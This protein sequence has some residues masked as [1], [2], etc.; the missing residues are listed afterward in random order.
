MSTKF[1]VL[2]KNGDMGIW[3]MAVD[4]AIRTDK[5]ICQG[6]DQIHGTQ[7][8]YQGPE[9]VLQFDSDLFLELP[10]NAEEFDL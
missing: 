5:R 6:Q 9:A 7:K 2:S 10:I 1:N 3:P 4:L 8:P